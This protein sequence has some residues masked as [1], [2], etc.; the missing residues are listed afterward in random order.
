MG[1]AR[2]ER[3]QL[4]NLFT[5]VGPDAPTLCDGWT[6]R[7]LAAHLVVRERRLDA[8]PGIMIKALAGYTARVQRSYAARPWPELVDLVR[9]GPPVLSPFRLVDE[10][11]NTTEYFIHHED[12]RRAA[13][14]WEP[15]PAD[16]TRDRALWAALSRTARLYYRRSPVGVV[17]RTPDGRAITARA[18]ADPVTITGE[19]GELLLDAFGRTKTRI[20]HTGPEA[21]IATVR[22]LRRGL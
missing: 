3:A 18:G 2:D 22:S 21:A 10:Q 4:S 13:P 15:R 19:P 12:V 17:L 7:D 5:E 14:G 8:A 16:E 20:D 1:V 6:S 9:T 11:V